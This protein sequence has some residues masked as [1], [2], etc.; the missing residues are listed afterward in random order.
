M[1]TVLVQRTGMNG[2]KILR[3]KFGTPDIMTSSEISPVMARYLESF[4]FFFIATSNKNGECK[5]SF[6]SR[7]NGSP[8]IKILRGE[9][10]IFPE[11]IGNETFGGLEN[12]RENPHIGML[13]MDLKT[14]LRIR[15]NGE[16]A[17]TEYP[18]WMTIFPGCLRVVKVRVQEIYKQNR[19]VSL[20]DSAVSV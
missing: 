15:V 1:A 12:I 11:Y 14:G 6:S 18:G 2:D 3:E 5:A 9:M 19:P 10:I 16:A 8:A 7:R 13:F 4:D 20:G 17:F